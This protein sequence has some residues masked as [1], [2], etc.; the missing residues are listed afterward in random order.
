MDEENTQEEEIIEESE[1]SV[2]TAEVRNN[3]AIQGTNPLAR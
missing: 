2:E 3:I 1:T